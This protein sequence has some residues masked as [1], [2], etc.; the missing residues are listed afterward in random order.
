ML[1][2]IDRGLAMGALAHVLV[3]CGDGG[4]S[5]SVPVIGTGGDSNGGSSSSAASLPTGTVSDGTSPAPPS[6]VGAPTG[7]VETGSRAIPSTLY[8]GSDTESFDTFWKCYDEGVTDPAAY[9]SFLFATNMRGGYYASG[10]AYAFGYTISDD[11]IQLQLDG[12]AADAQLLDILFDGT[13]LLF[14]TNF[15][16][17][18]RDNVQTCGKSDLEGRALG[19]SPLDATVTHPRDP[20]FVNSS[21]GATLEDTWRCVVDDDASAFFLMSLLADGNAIIA[22][23]ASEAV[24]TR[25]RVAASGDLLVGESRIASPTFGGPDRFTS[26]D[27]FVRGNERAGTLDCTR[28][29]IGPAT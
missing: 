7:T 21:V 16:V 13:G 20:R 14:S 6:R 10:N 1:E 17:D 27:Y 29:D 25:W 24:T 5:S 18:G 19:R 28:I 11:T 3:A 12:L 15:R 23:S 2:R 22:Y 26:E 9:T 4:G 8:N